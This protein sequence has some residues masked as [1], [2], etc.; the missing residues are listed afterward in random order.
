MAEVKSRKKNLRIRAALAGASMTQGD[1]AR[2]LGYSE[3]D[4]S[5]IMSVEL[6]KAE[7]DEIIKKIREIATS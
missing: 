1:L 5:I 3:P 2:L 7:Q 4:L 6:A